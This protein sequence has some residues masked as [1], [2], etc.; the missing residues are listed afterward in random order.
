MVVM[1]AMNH[2]NGDRLIAMYNRIE[3]AH[4][5]TVYDRFLNNRSEEESTRLAEVVLAE[6]EDAW[7][8]F[9]SEEVHTFSRFVLDVYQAYSLELD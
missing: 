2:F 1:D 6:T 8:E 3:R 9:Y 5:A 7:V 4:R